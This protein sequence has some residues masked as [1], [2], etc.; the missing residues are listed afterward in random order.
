[1]RISRKPIIDPAKVIL[2]LIRFL[3]QNRRAFE[4][5]SRKE[6][7]KL[8]NENSAQIEIITNEIIEI[9]K[10]IGRNK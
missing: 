1:M 3:L 9:K 8:R 2:S 6:K 10:L 4:G 7:R 5:R